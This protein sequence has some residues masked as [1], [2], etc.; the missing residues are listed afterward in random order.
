MDTGANVTVSSEVLQS[1][2]FEII[3]A[4]R[5]PKGKVDS[6]GHEYWPQIK[7]VLFVNF[8]ESSDEDKGFIH[9]SDT[10]YHEVEDASS[11]SSTGEGALQGTQRKWT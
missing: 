11:G 1:V 7:L 2:D 4:D 6:K 3:P 10:E 9:K 8:I 5:I